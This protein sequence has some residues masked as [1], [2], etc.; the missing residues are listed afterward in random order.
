LHVRKVPLRRTDAADHFRPQ[1]Q[2]QATWAGIARIRMRSAQ[3]LPPLADNIDK[4][5][6]IV[7]AILEAYTG[8]GFPYTPLRPAG[9]ALHW[10]FLS[11]P[12]RFIHMKFLHLYIRVL[13]VLGP[14]ARLGWILAGAA[15]ALASAQ[16]IEPVLFGRIVDVLANAQ[17]GLRPLSW[18]NL[19]LPLGAWVG[20]ALFIIACSTLVALHADRL[21]H[22]HS[23]KVRTDYFEHV[24]QL[25]L[26]YHT[27]TH[28][29][30]LM[31]V[32]LTGTTTLWNLWLNFFRENLTSLVSLL[33]LMPLT[34]ALN[35]R[36]GLLLIALCGVFAVLI[37]LV[38]H[39]SETLQRAV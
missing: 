39:K 9:T 17:G 37:G 19:L 10:A 1:R 15:V 30:R 12:A 22:R 23:Q 34:L 14:E 20:F 27:G 8:T 4:N 29:G 24:L 35:W 7:T 33:V 3:L 11:L 28:S 6:L 26:S 21:A 32:M 31:K 16:F 25:P 13:A 18:A 38:L 5:I 2:I 36:F